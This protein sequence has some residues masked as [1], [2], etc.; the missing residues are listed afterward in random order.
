[1]QMHFT[2]ECELMSMKHMDVLITE[3]TSYP[4]SHLFS[5]MESVV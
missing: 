5:V 4:H 2:L 3:Y 1:M